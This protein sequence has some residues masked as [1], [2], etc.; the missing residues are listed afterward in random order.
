MSRQKT[1]TKNISDPVVGEIFNQI[2]S[3]EG[4]THIV[5]EKVSTI[6]ESLN[7]VKRSF[8][9]LS[10]FLKKDAEFDIW[11][12]ELEEFN[13][14]IKKL[15]VE[16]VDSKKP[17]DAFNTYKDSVVTKNLISSCAYLREYS[18][19]LEATPPEDKW[20]NENDGFPIVPFR[21]TSMDLNRIWIS[22][23]QTQF[24]N[25]VLQCIA[26]AYINSYVIYRNITSPNINVKEFAQKL[27]GKLSDLES[28]PE[29]SRCKDALKKIR[30]AVDMLEDNF[31]EY[32]KDSVQSRNPN[33]I[34]ENFILDV[35]KSQQTD[36]KIIR[37]FK[38]IIKFIRKHSQK[39]PA[40]DP[41]IAQM[42][43]ILTENINSTENLFK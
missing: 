22:D 26:K 12:N 7:I 14:S 39:L 27:V 3:G 20:L 4:D 19:Y 21:F 42:F 40:K 31:E 5:T 24:K 2:I 8:G 38:D 34:F 36:L 29:L 35:S 37:Q 28:H 15:E 10:S 1:Y 43:D 32:Y 17:I 16:V 41:R 23:V 9:I 30:D 25:I 13:D 33:L 6:K 11:G 18:K